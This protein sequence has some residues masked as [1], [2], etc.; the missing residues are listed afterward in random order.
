PSPPHPPPPTPPGIAPD[1]MGGA[2]VVWQDHRAGFEQTYAQRIASDG[3]AAWVAGGIALSSHPTRA[4]TLRSECCV[5][6]VRAGSIAPDGVGGALV[7]WTDYRSGAGF[8]SGDIVA[9]RLGPDGR[10]GAGWPV[11]GLLVCGA[12]GEQELPTV[13]ADDQGGVFVAWQDG[14]SS[15]W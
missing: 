1:G 14:R 10:P 9:Q 7:G 11:E 5:D 3:G 2:I 4:G 13:A 8:G 12:A 15:E 6:T